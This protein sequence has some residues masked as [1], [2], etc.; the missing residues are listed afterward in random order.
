[1]A[2]LIAGSRLEQVLT[3]G[4]F[5]VTAEINPRDGADPDRI[6]EHGTAL[7]A[8]CDALN[9]PDA[10]GA[11]VHISGL[12]VCALLIRQGIEPVMQLTCRDRNRIALQGELLGGAAL[13]VRNLLCLTGDGVQ[14]GDQPEAKAVFDFDSIALL[15]SA[16]ILRDEGHFLNGRA[17]DAAPRLFLGAAENPFAP[18]LDF[19]PLRLQKKIEAGANFIQTQFC[20]DVPQ[21]Q[22][23]MK[24]VRQL[25]LH[26]R[27]FILAGVGPLRSARSAEW[28][29]T[30][31][32]GVVI[33]DQVIRRMSALPEAR[34]AEEGRH[35]CIEI[36]QQVREIEGV[37]GVHIMAYHNEE[38]AAEII[39]EAGLLPRPALGA[40]RA[41][42]TRRPGSMPS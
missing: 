20:F 30:H 36:I 18:P 12:A 3:S 4:E 5:A 19:R 14:S 39:T 9:V 13:G 29:R 10:S 42:G 31:V 35:I 25:G 2:A 41:V 7:A 40:T 15:Q 23:F 8:A 17:V 37:R 21:L 22:R 28:M 27:A 16:R 26:E 11:N 34:Q 1:M 32:P 24:T 38:L 6:I 33:P